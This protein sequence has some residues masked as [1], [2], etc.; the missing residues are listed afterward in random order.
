MKLE[1]SLVGHSNFVN[2]VAF[3]PDGKTLASC[4]GDLGSRGEILLWDIGNLPLR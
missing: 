2:A 3:S 4:D 1:L